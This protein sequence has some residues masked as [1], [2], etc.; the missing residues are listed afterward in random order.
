MNSGK[1]YFSQQLNIKYITFLRRI[2]F[3]HKKIKKGF[4]QMYKNKKNNPRNT[5]IY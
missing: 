4:L 2:L 5:S 3:L 1:L